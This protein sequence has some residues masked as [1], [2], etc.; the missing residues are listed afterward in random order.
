MVKTESGAKV[1]ELLSEYRARRDFSKTTEPDHAPPS[2]P[3]DALTFVVQKH[4]AT[5]LHY[6]FRLEWG[7]VLKSW[8][9]TR[10]PSYDP[11][12]KRLAVRTEDHPIAY[13][14]FEGIIPENEYGGGTVMLWDHGTW[15]PVGDFEKGLKE[16]KLVFRLAGQRLVGEWTLV[17]MKP[18]PGEKR[19]NWLMIKHREEGFVPPRGDVLK[20][21]VKSVT[22]GRSMA[23][24]AKGGRTLA[25]SDLTNRKPAALPV[26]AGVTAKPAGAATPPVAGKAPRKAGSAL[27]MP[28]F[29]AP[30]LATLVGE[31]PDGDEWIS[32]MKYDGYRALIA[33]AGG[34]ARVF[35]R[36]GLDWTDKF[37]GIAA[38]AAALP[39]GRAQLDGEIVAFDRN[40]KTDFSALQEAIKAGGKGLSCFLFDLLEQ[41][42]ADL[43]KLTLVDRKAKLE[44]LLGQG[45]APLIYSTHVAGR[46]GDVF[47]QVCAAGHEGIVAKRA[48]APYR[49][50]RG[51]AWLKVKCGKRQEFVVGGYSPSDKSGRTVRSL[52]VGVNE[53]GKLIYKGRVGSF[54]GDT[55]AEIETL[56][57]A[58]PRKASP[59][60][61]V[62]AEAARGARYVDPD[63]VVEVEFAEFTADGVIRHGVLKGTRGDK[64]AGDVVLE[65]PEETTMEHESR[66]VIAGVKLSN[67]DKVLFADQ[68]ITKAD[69][70]A[71]YERVASR[72]LPLMEKRLLSL[73]RCPDG[74]SGQCFFQKHESK[75]FPPELKLLPITENDGDKANY[76]YADSLAALIAGVQM[77]TLEF[78]IWGSRID[79]L[80]KPERL[81]FDLDPDED[82]GF[83]DVRDAALDLRDRL[84]RIGLKTLA[85]V[86]GGKGVHVIAPLQRRAEWPKV[87]AFA[88]G[89]AKLLEDEAPDRYVANM[90]K[91]K[92]KGR[93]FVD[94]L[95]NERGSTAIAPYSTRVRPGAPVATPVS[96]DELKG[97]QAANA[98]HIGDMASRMAAPDPWAEAAGWKQSLTKAMLK[99]VGEG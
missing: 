21:F 13:G 69:L 87:K 23:E 38:A 73:V 43:I 82:L 20:K 80:E 40:G 4:D 75:G 17:R 76:L 10:G 95:R 7:G 33:V 67:P 6:D 45:S 70:A 56:L 86:T 92:R 63:L 12:E 72:M 26:A 58:R 2:K 27:A 48:D 94:Y 77:S 60:E 24:I 46:A 54:E 83:A 28:R 85:M 99:K 35:T 5:R 65:V 64:A 49:S 68:G 37:P 74:A 55:L 78:H 59:F 51:R 81:V 9:V 88:R 18:R 32:E 11:A 8:A 52:L 62:P 47:R 16:G 31:A 53:G 57:A 71:H 3:A 90:A 97:L 30:Q 61:A 39:A 98:F 96:W 14:A 15:E 1:D 84:A 66:A 19:E 22:T 91:A 25:K 79:Q 36:S 41:D 50:G 93:I 89:F 34:K 44:A 42:G 29:R